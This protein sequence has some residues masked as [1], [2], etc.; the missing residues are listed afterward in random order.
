VYVCV[1]ARTRERAIGRWRQPTPSLGKVCSDGHMSKSVELMVC[2]FCVLFS[3]CDVSA[4]PCTGGQ[5]EYA[6]GGGRRGR[7]CVCVCVFL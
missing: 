1:R 3:C 6:W 2:F 7:M 4:L 5:N